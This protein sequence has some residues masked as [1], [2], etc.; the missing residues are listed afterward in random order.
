M[1]CT[2]SSAK[3]TAVYDLVVGADGTQ[4]KVRDVAFDKKEFRTVKRFEKWGYYT[5]TVT[6]PM[7]IPSDQMSVYW[8]VD[9]PPPKAVMTDSYPLQGQR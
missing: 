6:R 4:S 7:A 8:C 2:F 3:P 5:T 9:S 1:T